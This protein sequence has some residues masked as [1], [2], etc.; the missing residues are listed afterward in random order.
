MQGYDRSPESAAAI[1]AFLEQ[2]WEVNPAIARA[3][4]ALLPA[5]LAAP[6]EGEG[7]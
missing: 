6:G 3:I 1:L 4:R 2:H 5:D 7:V